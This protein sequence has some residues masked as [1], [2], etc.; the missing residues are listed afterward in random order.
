MTTTTRQPNSG[1]DYDPTQRETMNNPFPVFARLQREAPIYWSVKLNGWVVTRFED[2]K[3]I[4]LDKRF[5]SERMKPFFEAMPA[6]QRAG[7]ENL[8]SSVG[9]WTVFLDPPDHTRLRRLLN[10]GFTS[11]AVNGMAPRIAEIVHD[12]IDAVTHQTEI[13]FVRDIAFRIPASVIMEML[14]APSSEIHNFK[15]WSDE[16][17]LFVGGARVT[18]DKYA[19]AEAATAQMSNA[20]RD[21][22]AERR[23]KP[24]N[25]MITALIRAEEEGE[26]LDDRELIATC[27]QL[28]FA[29]HETTSNLLATGLYYLLKHP[30]QLVDLRRHPELGEQVVEEVLRHDGPNAAVTRV[31]GADIDFRGHPIT[32][33]QRVFAMINAAN[34]DPEV[35]NNPQQFDIRRVVPNNTAIGQF[36][37]GHGIHFCIGAPLARLEGRIAFPIFAQRLLNPRL[38]GGEPDWIDSLSFRGLEKLPITC[39]FAPRQL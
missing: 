1:P 4:L 30:D 23:R 15:L 37:F 5:S 24:R 3:A 27:I 17:G 28:L 33:G 16:I 20:F 31:A 11:R 14:G 13:E 8:Q 32:R 6:A 25:D 36:A 19:R 22:I 7:V 39:D 2:C 38:S 9:L 34:R 26:V 18:P 21:L 29:G 10:S 12:V 35:F